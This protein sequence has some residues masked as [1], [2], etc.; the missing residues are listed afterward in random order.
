MAVPYTEI[1]ESGTDFVV[2]QYDE[3]GTLIQSDTI[4]QGTAALTVGDSFLRIQQTTGE[5]LDVEPADI[6]LPVWSD[7]K[8]L[9][10]QVAVI[11]GIKTP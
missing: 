3:L 9:A 8:D 10:D 11:M 6:T 4:A 1:Y 2:D 5:I 7:L